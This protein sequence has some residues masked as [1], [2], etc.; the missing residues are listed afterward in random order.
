MITR[1]LCLNAM[2]DIL[3]CKYIITGTVALKD[4]PKYIKKLVHVGKYVLLNY[5]YDSLNSNLWYMGLWTPH[6]IQ[7][8]C[9]CCFVYFSA[10][11]YL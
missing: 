9:I 6:L 3:H 10:I 8:E 4:L 1:Y 7:S 2:L 11:Q 5:N